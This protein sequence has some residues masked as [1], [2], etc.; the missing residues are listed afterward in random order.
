MCFCQVEALFYPRSEAGEE[1]FGV[2][3]GHWRSL[4]RLVIDGWGDGSLEELA[5]PEIV[6]QN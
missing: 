5:V 4:E 2:F 6:G 1:G 3:G